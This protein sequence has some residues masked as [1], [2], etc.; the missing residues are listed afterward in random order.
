MTG[1][2]APN[3]NKLIKADL[4]TI[5]WLLTVPSLL[6]SKIKRLKYDIVEIEILTIFQSFFSMGILNELFSNLSSL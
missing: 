6:T 4:S 3:Q 2:K 1:Q 5:F